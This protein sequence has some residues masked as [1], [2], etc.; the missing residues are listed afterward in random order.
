[1][2]RTW[3]KLRY[4]SQCESAS[5]PRTSRRV[6]T[7]WQMSGA[8]PSPRE[9]ARTAQEAAAQLASMWDLQLA[10]PSKVNLFL[11]VLGK[12][13]D[14]YHDIASL[15]QAVSLHDDMYFA[16]LPP[17]ATA[18]ELEC[19]EPGVP[20]DDSNLV[21]KAFKA[22]RKRTG[23]EMY[24]RVH[25]DKRIPAEAG[26]GGGSGNA[27]T[28]LWAANELSGKSLTSKD[29]A[30]IGA[31]FGSDV[32]FF[33]SMGTAY[34]TGRGEILKLLDRLLPQTL[35]L[36]KPTEGLSTAEVFKKLDLSQT[37]DADPEVLLKQIQT[38]IFVCCDYVND[39]EKPS[40]ELVPRLAVIKTALEDAGFNK[41]AMSG[42]GTTFFC[43][44]EPDREMFGD[45]FALIFSANYDVQV[46]RGMFVWRR[47]PNYWYL[48]T[49]PLD[50]LSEYRDERLV[51]KGLS[52]ES[53]E[54]FLVNRQQ[55]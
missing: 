3:Q 44:G 45:N 11:R 17:E 50:E 34:C 13:P 21:I 20:S 15:F 51:N 41:V 37:S 43:M 53:P 6:R 28:A 39:L 47:H 52:G 29:L 35:W 9:E 32:S 2:P 38:K 26:L 1:M 10:S 33:F 23:I 25:L 24:F 54:P 40:F 5:I 12:R 36:V 7:T 8:K 49:P 55:P 22:F 4:S 48:Q 19:T 27:A 31:E 16:V 14:G 42:S 46:M 18:D 30:D